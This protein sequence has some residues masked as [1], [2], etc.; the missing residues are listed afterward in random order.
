MK[1]SMFKKISIIGVGLIGGSIGLAAKEKKLAGV[2]T[3]LTTSRKTLNT[4]LKSQAIDRGTLDL[5]QCV[6]GADVVILAAPVS[7]FEKI[8]KEIGPC[9]KKGCIVTDI[10]STKREAVRTAEKILPKAVFFVG[11]HPM[12]G[13]EKKGVKFASA[14]LFKNSVLIITP[15]SKTDKKSLSRINKFWQSLGAEVTLLSPQKHDAAVAFVSHL[16][17]A[18]AVSLTNTVPAANFKFAA[19]G[20]KDVTRIAESSETIWQSIFA[21]NRQE[22]SEK[23]NLFIKELTNLKKALNNRNSQRLK[24]MLKQARKKRSRI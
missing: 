16:P 8:L 1:K 9:L 2:I 5:K 22:I 6:E 12:A 19:G 20:F 4:A 15:T 10:A 3:G 13:S 23:I 17:H 18:V 7:K 11:A 24:L 14:G 21:S